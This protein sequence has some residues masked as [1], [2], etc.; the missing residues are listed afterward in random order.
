[1]AS[2]S[3]PAPPALPGV[4]DSVL[5]LIGETPIVRLRRLSPAGGPQ[6]LVKLE[7]RNPGGSAKDRPA[8]S[9]VQDAEASGALAPDAPIVESTSGN[10]G[11]GLALVG[12]LTGHPVVIVH[13]GAMSP[14]KLT[15]LRLY[16]AE[17]VEADWLAGPDDPGNPR[18]VADRIAAERGGWRSHQYD[19]PANPGAHYRFTGPEIWRQ[20]GG[21]ITHLVAGIGTG[22]TISGTGRYLREV[23]HDRVRVVGANP[24]GSTYA[25]GP[26]GTI[27]VEGVGTT[28]PSSHWPRNLDTAVPHEIRTIPDEA[29]FAALRRLA[30]EEALLLGPSSGLA[31]AAALELAA[32]LGPHDVIVAV[33]PDSATNYLTELSR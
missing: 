9:L 17:L 26:S 13:G 21:A 19:N 11:I 28:W 3:A 20:T 29:A 32:G 25:G 5:D 31:V 4:A 10:T 15:L 8:L 33:S 22:G 30:E 7:G 18:A 23:S 14:E 2:T 12:R 1:M 6:V 16:G 24:A 27:R